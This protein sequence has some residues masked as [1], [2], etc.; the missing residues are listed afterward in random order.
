[1]RNTLLALA[2]ALPFIAR[3]QSPKE[4]IV[5]PKD[6]IPQDLVDRLM[7]TRFADMQFTPE[8]VN[9][10]INNP[11]SSESQV[12]LAFV[13]YLKEF[14]AMKQVAVSPSQHDEL[15]SMAPSQCDIVGAGIEMG[16][17]KSDFLAVGRIPTTMVFGFCDQVVY[18]VQMTVGVN[19]NTNP[20]KRF[21]RAFYETL[22][23]N[24]KD[25][26]YR[27]TLPTGFKMDNA[28][29]LAREAQSLKIEGVYE[30]F[31]ANGPTPEKVAI[32][33]DGETI[34]L[35]HLSGGY[36]PHDW[37]EGEQ[38]GIL[39]PTASERDYKGQFN[40]SLKTGY[41]TSVTFENENAFSYTRRNGKSYKY[42]RVK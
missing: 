14:V 18:K 28:E 32:Y 23:T 5:G 11:N 17:F 20:Y 13:D 4:I 37:A 19:G 6:H 15:Y 27:L 25:T 29:K 9:L 31:E 24:K 39:F 40:S 16:E 8:M 26:K 42:I 1:M 35:L 12:L 41:Q 30:L 7:G 33:K 21:K 38:I 22:S 10:V 3:S 36:L 34:R 2:L